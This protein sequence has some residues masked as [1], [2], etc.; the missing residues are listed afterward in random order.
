MSA[1]EPSCTQTKGDSIMPLL[2]TV[3]NK[4]EVVDK[5]LDDLGA[6]LGLMNMHYSLK[7]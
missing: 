5:M 4:K 7:Q 1:C 3:K 2:S 6:E